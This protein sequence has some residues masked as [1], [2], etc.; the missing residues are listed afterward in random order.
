MRAIAIEGLA[1]SG[2]SSQLP[3]IEA[4][5]KGER[6][7]A[8]IFAGVFAAAMLGN[9]PIERIAD[10]LSRS[11]SRNMAKQYLTE[12]ARVHVDRLSRYAQDPNPAIRADIADIVG[13][14]DDEAGL[15][16]VEALAR[17]QDALVALSAQRAVARLRADR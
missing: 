8:V 14:S 11:T 15:P 12:I 10:T 9:G 2:D 17:D 7:D 5:T 4:A 16:I 6:S 13:F 3:A 1:R